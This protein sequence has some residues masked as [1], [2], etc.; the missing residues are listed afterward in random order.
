MI[1]GEN[2]SIFIDTME[3]IDAAKSVVDDFSKI[4]NKPTRAVIYTHYHSDHIFG[5]SAYINNSDNFIIISHKNMINHIDNLFSVIQEIA[6]VRGMRQFGKFIGKNNIGCGIGPHVKFGNGERISVIYPNITFDKS[7]NIT[8]EGIKFEIYS[9]P[10]ESD[11]QICVWL[12]DYK[13]LL[14]ADNYYEAF[15][16]LYTIRGSETRFISHWLKTLEFMI[17]LEPEILVPSH[18]LPIYGKDVIKTR[19]TNYRN[20]I[21]IVNDQTIRYMNRG[22]EPN[23]IAEKIKLPK[24]LS[25]LSYLRPWYGNIEHSVKGIF[26]QYLGWFSGKAVHLKPLS[27]FE[28]ATKILSL[29]NDINILYEHAVN[30]YNN[31]EYQWALELVTILKTLNKNKDFKNLDELNRNILIKMAENEIS[32]NTRNYYYSEAYEIFNKIKPGKIEQENLFDNNSIEN[33]LKMMTTRLIFEKAEYIDMGVNFNFTDIKKCM[34][35]HVYYGVC[36][37]YN[38]CKK[39]FTNITTTRDVW[40]ETISNVGS[41]FVNYYLGKISFDGNFLDLLGLYSFFD[42]FERP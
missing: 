26:N 6:Y 29:V 7:L 12:P 8:I 40:I 34:S 37:F 2:G 20:A 5:T 19:L 39:H 33:I 14:S 18:T 13:I 41:I 16:N 32:A 28:Y 25:N 1:N 3:S 38:F 24:Y 21:K 35:L 17:S 9:C 10:G 31:E 4:S 11:D 30:A 36:D 42:L 23:E 22:L 15:P 27:N